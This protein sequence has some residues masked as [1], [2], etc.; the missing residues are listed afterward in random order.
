M[1]AA[2]REP[3]HT[4]DPTA[5]VP[6]QLA[7]GIAVH[8]TIAT[9]CVLD[10]RDRR[11][12]D[13]STVAA[14]ASAALGRV[15]MTR[16]NRYLVPRVVEYACLYADRFLPPQDW[17][18]IGAE[19]P[20]DGGRRV[21]LAWAD[22]RSGGRPAKPQVLLDEIKVDG[23][24]DRTRQR[25]TWEQQALDYLQLAAAQRRVDVLGVRVLTLNTPRRSVL[26][27][28]D[29]AK[30]LLVDTPYCDEGGWTAKRTRRDRT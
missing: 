22:P 11:F 6:T 13:F 4:S 19:V 2:A 9:L 28:S 10:D 20:L 17:T 29:S 21:D 30:K 1:A 27:T 23:Y 8:R 5:A 18:F 3:D 24:V 26:L 12:R 25:T 16:E 14:A 15:P 7:V